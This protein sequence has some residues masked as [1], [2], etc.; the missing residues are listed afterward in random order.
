MAAF[1]PPTTRCARAG[2]SSSD[3]CLA[4]Q[5]VAIVR[6]Q[7]QAE[8]VFEGPVRLMGQ[9]V[10]AATLRLTQILPVRRPV[11]G[12]AIADPI[13]ERFG[14]IYRVAVHLLPFLRQHTSHAPEQMRGQVLD[15]N[16]G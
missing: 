14:K 4:Y 3:S 7:R 8:D 5:A 13:D 16:P 12:A 9:I 15:L 10:L 2:V 1:P 11:A 6:A